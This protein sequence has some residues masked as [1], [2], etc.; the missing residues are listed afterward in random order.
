M[1]ALIVL[2]MAIVTWS[3]ITTAQPPKQAVQP[4]T[5]PPVATK[6]VKQYGTSITTQQLLNE[7]NLWRVGNKLDPLT[8]NSMLEVSA[9]A[10][11]GDMES[12]NYWSHY[13]PDGEEPWIFFRSAGYE[14][15]KAGENL[16]RNLNTAHDV[17]VAWELSPTHNQNLLGNYKEVG[18]AVC[19]G[20][21]GTIIVQHLG[22]TD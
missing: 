4:I 20:Q 1:K 7:T 16:A 11:C 6:V 21:A 2:C 17:V 8:T 5:K 15:T 3:V 10:K 9:K 14:Y 22:R 12:R 19:Y 18:Y 13:T